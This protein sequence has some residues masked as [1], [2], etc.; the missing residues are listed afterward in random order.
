MLE[1]DLLESLKN[2]YGIKATQL[3][4]LPFSADPNA[5]VYKASTKEGFSYFVKL[6]RGHSE[7][8]SARLLSLLHTA[9]IQQILAPIKTIQGK[10]LKQMPD[11]TLL[12]YPFIEGQNGFCA[13]LK[14]KQWMSLGKILKQVHSFNLPLLIQEQIR[15]EVYP[16]HWQETVR[17]SCFRM[18]S[19]PAGDEIAFKL[20]QF[21]K[22][23]E[24]T[25]HRLVDQSE[26]LRQKALKQTPLLVLCHSDIHAGNVLIDIHDS[27][28]VVDWDDPILAPKE[29]D[30]MFI[31]GGVA[32]VW[33]QPDEEKFF[34]QGYGKTEINWILMA[35]YRHVRIVEDIALYI[36]DLF[37]KSTHAKEKEEMYHQ[38][39]AMFEP[40]GVIEIAFK[41]HLIAEKF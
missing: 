5:S 14:E 18:Q 32:N 8:L 17:S 2:D 10:F 15:K 33:N 29:R 37:F 11:S 20:Q 41:T 9:G 13:P 1:N 24:K 22:A 28:Y 12:V 7:D 35:Y 26:E 21:I 34:Y 39:I 27:I 19:E 16:S 25:I 38:F 6:K 40:Y 23:H 31:G 30:L 4:P 3:S 36:H